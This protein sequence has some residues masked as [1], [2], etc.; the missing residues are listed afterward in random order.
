MREQVVYG[1]KDLRIIKTPDGE[2]RDIIFD[3]GMGI[4]FTLLDEFQ[5]GQRRKGFCQGADHEAGVFCNGNFFSDIPVPIASR[6]DHPAFMHQ[7]DSGARDPMFLQVISDDGIEN[8]D[9]S[10]EIPLFEDRLI[11]VEGAA[12]QG[13]KDQ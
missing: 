3:I 1:D 5:H 9:R 8:G 12:T 13:K 10:F 11:G 7:G 6:E 4:D 2:I